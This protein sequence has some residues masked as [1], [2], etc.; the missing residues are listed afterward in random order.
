MTLLRNYRIP[1]RRLSEATH[2]TTG[3]GPHFCPQEDPVWGSD[4]NKAPSSTTEEEPGAGVIS[5]PVRGKATGR[6]LS[7]HRGRQS[8]PR[9]RQ[10]FLLIRKDPEAGAVAKKRKGAAEDEAG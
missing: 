10:C 9:N 5:V 2:V 6:E 4:Y 3:L 8:P 1:G 7:G